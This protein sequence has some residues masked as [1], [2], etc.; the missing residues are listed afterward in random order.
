M[1]TV[2]EKNT[3]YLTVNFYNKSGALD[4]PNTI[5]YRIDDVASGSAVRADTAI[6]AVASSVEIRLTATDNTILNT[7]NR[8]ERRRVTVTATYGVADQVTD[9]FYYEIVSLVKVT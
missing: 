2:T 5:T 3:A 6:G 8:S 9:E 1:Q 4:V 7:N